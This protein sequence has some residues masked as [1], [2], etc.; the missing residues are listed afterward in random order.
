MLVTDFLE[1]KLL[2]KA[3]CLMNLKQLM[4]KVRLP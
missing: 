4:K 1:V 3:C 2:L